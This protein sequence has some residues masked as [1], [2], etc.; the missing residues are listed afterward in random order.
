MMQALNEMILGFENKN[1]TF[2]SIVAANDIILSH[3]W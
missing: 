2:K 3:I 1:Y